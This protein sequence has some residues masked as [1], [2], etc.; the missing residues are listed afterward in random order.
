M[1]LV[2][3]A[4]TLCGSLSVARR[5][6]EPSCPACSSKK[7]SDTPSRLQCAHCGW[8]NVAMAPVLAAEPPI[9]YEIALT[10]S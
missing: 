3:L 10:E 5:F 2:A 4:L 1:Y 9:Q 6:V 7:W 8:S